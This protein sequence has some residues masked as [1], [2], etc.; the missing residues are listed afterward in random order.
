MQAT[1][2]LLYSPQ[3]SYP[4][5]LSP[6]GIPVQSHQFPSHLYLVNIVVWDRLGLQNSYSS[7]FR[8]QLTYSSVQGVPLP[9]STDHLPSPVEGL[10]RVSKLCGSSSSDEPD[11]SPTSLLRGQSSLPN[12]RLRP[13]DSFSSPPSSTTMVVAGPSLLALL[14]QWTSC[15]PTLFVETN[16]CK[17]A[18]DLHVWTFSSKPFPEPSV[19]KQCQTFS[20]VTRVHPVTNTSWAG[21]LS[22]NSWPGS[23]LHKFLRTLPTNSSLL[24]FKRKASSHPP[25]WCIMRLS[26]TLFYAF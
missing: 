10:L 23:P 19:P 24:S 9:S 17:D 7:Y 11:S 13:T 4:E 21:K 18:W 22:S 1:G 26:K 15:P 6:L 5:A 14:A 2:I 25:L 16:T 8:G 3:V 12:L 20:V